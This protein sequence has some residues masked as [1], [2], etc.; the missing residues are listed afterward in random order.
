MK[1]TYSEKKA[2]LEG[3]CGKDILTGL[4][5]Q[6]ADHFYKAM[7]DNGMGFYDADAYAWLNTLFGYDIGADHAKGIIRWLYENDQ[8]ALEFES[9]MKGTMENIC[10]LELG[11]KLDFSKWPEDTPVGI[12]YGY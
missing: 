4:T 5:Q 1:K 7:H 10:N 12:R 11:F 9:G 8:N 3:T 2:W 6:A